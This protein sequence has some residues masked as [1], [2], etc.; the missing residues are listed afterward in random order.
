M[1]RGLNK[2]GAIRR[3]DYTERSDD[4]D[5]LAPREM[6]SRGD[7]LFLNTIFLPDLT[8]FIQ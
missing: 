3:M 4:D 1:E 8:L 6:R 2:Q 5:N 7:R